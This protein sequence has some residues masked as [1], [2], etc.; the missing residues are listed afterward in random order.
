MSFSEKLQANT[1]LIMNQL[2]WELMPQKL[3]AE[4]SYGNYFFKIWQESNVNNP[5]GNE[6]DGLA[7]PCSA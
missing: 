2:P 4:H 5:K 3:E 6:P 7:C 1:K